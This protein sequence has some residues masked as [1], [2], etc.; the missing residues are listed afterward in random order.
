VAL[1]ARPA[2]HGK[3]K[4][5][6]MCCRPRARHT[7][8]LLAAAQAVAESVPKRKEMTCERGVA[9][10]LAMCMVPSN[11]ENDYGVVGPMPPVI[12]SAG[13]PM[14]G[15]QWFREALP[16][17]SGFSLLGFFPAPFEPPRH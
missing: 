2:T 9:A 7:A 6:G 1:L 13:V 17:L 5:T 14:A 10:H 15:P 3:A 16:Q 8:D 4:C 11:S 12:L